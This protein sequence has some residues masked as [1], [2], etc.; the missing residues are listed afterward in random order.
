VN[1]CENSFG[2]TGDPNSENSCHQVDNP[3]L[4]H[5]LT[6]DEW[7]HNVMWLL[8]ISC[9]SFIY[10]RTDGNKALKEIYFLLPVWVQWEWVVLGTI[11]SELI[12]LN[13]H[14]QTPA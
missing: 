7:N 1:F 9:G 13:M 6:G 8:D 10:T 4:L 3:E 11:V 12:N 5:H 2:N 14:N